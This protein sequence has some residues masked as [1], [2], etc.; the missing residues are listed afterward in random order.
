VPTGPGTIDPTT[1]DPC[2][3]ITAADASRLLGGA[4]KHFAPEQEPDDKDEFVACGYRSA[5]GH[6]TLLVD[7]AI[8][9]NAAYSF[10]SYW[11]PGADGGPMAAV[12]TPIPHLGDKAY[13]LVFRKH[14]GE[15]ATRNLGVLAHGVVV[16][17]HASGAPAAPGRAA[18]VATARAALS[19]IR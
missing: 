18:L 7:V 12:S 3:L 11:G 9:Q 8:D 2:A 6:R 19:R 10:D 14:P 5:A 13:Q 15:P 1:L 17:L 4:A 16:E